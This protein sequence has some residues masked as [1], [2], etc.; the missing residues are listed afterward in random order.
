MQRIGSSGNAAEKGSC[1]IMAPI[2]F[3]VPAIALA[4]GSLWAIL[5]PIDSKVSDKSEL[6]CENIKN[7]ARKQYTGSKWTMDEILDLFEISWKV[8]EIRAATDKDTARAIWVLFGLFASSVAGLILSALQPF[9]IIPFYVELIAY[10]DVLVSA[11]FVVYVPLLYRVIKQ[12]L[13]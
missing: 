13:H 5:G 3:Y 1:E 10:I 8:R 9:L 6:R 7:N 12:V 11:V 4:I 2:T